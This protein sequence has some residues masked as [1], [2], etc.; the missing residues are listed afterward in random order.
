LYNSHFHSARPKVGSRN[1]CGPGRFRSDSLSERELAR[2]A[3][4][5]LLSIYIIIKPFGPL[6]QPD[7]SIAT[8]TSTPA[9]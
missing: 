3:P 6:Y 1:R 4:F 2:A 5:F 8:C 9:G 7:R